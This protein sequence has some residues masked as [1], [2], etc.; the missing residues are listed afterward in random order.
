MKVEW[1][2]DEASYHY[3]NCSK[4]Y[5]ARLTVRDDGTAQILTA[6]ESLEFENEEAASIWLGDEEYS[7]LEFLREDHPSDARLVPPAVD[8][9]AE[10]RKRLEIVLDPPHTRD[11]ADSV[12]GRV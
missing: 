1:W 5:L 8:S 3:S 4:V 12:P 7:L 10:L 9:D 2:Y 6:G 11:R